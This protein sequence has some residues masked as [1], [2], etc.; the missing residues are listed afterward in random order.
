MDKNKVIIDTNMN[1]SQY[2]VLEDIKN[3]IK[4][5]E[6]VICT[7]DEALQNLLFLDKIVGTL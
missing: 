1:F 4:K 6:S 5:E 7:T 2:N 3:K